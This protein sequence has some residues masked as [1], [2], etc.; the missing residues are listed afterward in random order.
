M[1]FRDNIGFRQ[2]KFPC[3]NILKNIN[4][5]RLY[6]PILEQ[7]QKISLY[8]YLEQQF[9]RF[10]KN[11]LPGMM[12]LSQLSAFDGLQQRVSKDESS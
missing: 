1:P 9:N 3:L 2:S 5:S 6:F 4:C 11:I 8:C 10:S 7:L 12:R